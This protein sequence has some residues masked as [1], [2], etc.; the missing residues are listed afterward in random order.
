VRE[1]ITKVNDLSALDPAA[2]LAR[3][4]DVRAARAQQIEERR[5]GLRVSTPTNRL[6]T[7]HLGWVIKQ[8]PSGLIDA[9]PH[10]APRS[11]R[12]LEDA[13]LVIKEALT[14]YPA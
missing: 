14:R 7:L 5:A 1:I 12:Y 13:A 8:E 9:N 10:T 3:I 6:I 11:Q 2:A 4:E